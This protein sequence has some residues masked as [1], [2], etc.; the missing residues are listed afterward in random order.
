MARAACLSGLYGTRK[1]KIS[2]DD[3]RWINSTGQ[4]SLEVPRD[5]PWGQ[6][7][8]GAFLAEAIFQG[9]DV[10]K[11]TSHLPV[12]CRD[13]RIDVPGR[14]QLRHNLVTPKGGTPQEARCGLQPEWIG[15]EYFGVHRYDRWW[16]RDDHSWG[17]RRIQSGEL[18][19]ACRGRGSDAAASDWW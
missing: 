9:D 13:L 11:A 17:V 12:P 4:C 15:N 1:P 19:R 3:L 7:S 8:P 2:E 16:L 10:S 6:D 5:V 14:E 18:C